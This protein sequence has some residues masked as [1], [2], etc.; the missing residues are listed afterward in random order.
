CAIIALVWALVA[1]RMA[2]PRHLSSL[3]INFGNLSIDEAIAMSAKLRLVP[4]VIE[5]VVLADDGVAYLKVE[6]D[7]LDKVALEG[8]LPE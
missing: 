1:L 5:A 7:K 2:P 8:L 6:K 4:G 3:L